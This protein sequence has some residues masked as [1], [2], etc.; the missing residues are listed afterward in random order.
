M[1]MTLRWLIHMI[2]SKIKK[3][4]LK[5]WKTIIIAM[6]N[7]ICFLLIFIPELIMFVILKNIFDNNFLNL[8]FELYILIKLTLMIKEIIIS[9]RINNY[10][11]FYDVKWLN[12]YMVFQKVDKKKMQDMDCNTKFEELKD[13]S[14][15][16]DAR[17]LKKNKCYIAITHDTIING[18]ENSKGFKI[19]KKLY[20]YTDNLDKLQYQIFLCKNTKNKCKIRRWGRLPRKFYYVRFKYEGVE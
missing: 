7:L 6:F 8:Y 14:N 10:F 2:I 4:S 5:V 15:K 18:I 12:L 20:L 9:K 17:F 13:M 11:I 19:K 16:L 3:M 1:K